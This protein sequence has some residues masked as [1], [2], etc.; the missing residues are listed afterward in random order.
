MPRRGARVGMAYTFLRWLRTGMAAAL[1]D[2]PQS[3]GAGRRATVSLGVAVATGTDSR[4][5]SVDLS[6]FGP[7]DVSGIDP[8]Q[9]ILA[10]PTP[11]TNDFEATFH[12]HVEF[13]RP[14]LPWLFT[15]FGPDTSGDLRPWICLVVVERGEHVELRPG[16]PPVLFVTGDEVGE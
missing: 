6:V 9:R 10:H 11:G 2:Q 3:S 1:G 8:R 4:V 12:A 14:D 5:A 7:G 13:D 15:P 16:P